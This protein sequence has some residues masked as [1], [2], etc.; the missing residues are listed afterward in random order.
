MEP[1]CNRRV[2]NPN[3]ELFAL[4]VPPCLTIFVNVHLVDAGVS[5]FAAAGARGDEEAAP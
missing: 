4:H 1:A 2:C 5:I 3:F